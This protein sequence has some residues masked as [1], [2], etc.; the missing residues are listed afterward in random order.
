AEQTD[1]VVD[2]LLLLPGLRVR[3]QEVG[4]V[5]RGPQVVHYASPLSVP[6]PLRLRR[7]GGRGA[8]HLGVGLPAE[9]SGR[10][11]TRPTRGRASLIGCPPA[12]PTAEDPRVDTHERTPYDD[13]VL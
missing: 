1:Q 7:T 6:R 13:V 5:L 10:S 12:G 4:H 2:R 11:T 8:V 9:A 3:G